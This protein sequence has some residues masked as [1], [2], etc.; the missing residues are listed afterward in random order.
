MRMDQDGYP[1]SEKVYRRERNFAV[2]DSVGV[3][4]MTREQ[5]VKEVMELPVFPVSASVVLVGVPAVV[6]AKENPEYAQMY[7]KA[8]IAAIDGMPIVKI[9]RKKGIL[10]ER[11]AAPDIMDPLFAESVKHGKRH[12]FY[13]GKNDDVLEKLKQNLEQKYPNIQIC[14]MYSPPFRALTA[15]EDRAVCDR[16]N[17][18]HTDFVWVGI[19]A[20]KQE[21][22]IQDH[23]NKISGTVMLGVGAGFDFFAGTLKKAPSWMEVAGLEWVFRLLVE[24]KRLWKRYIL[25][26]IKFI[27]YSITSRYACNNFS[28]LP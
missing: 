25:G 9:G 5:L 4:A 2:C 7:E 22:W 16:I 3:C 24:P 13:G 28:K 12:F 27:Y 10:C 23:R 18:A 14:G 1:S 21:L 6:M 26:G 8:T 11:C 17:A 19:G 20:P 15:E